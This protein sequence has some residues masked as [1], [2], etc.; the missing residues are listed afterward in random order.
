MIREFLDYTI[1]P[2]ASGIVALAHDLI[3]NNW[4]VRRLDRPRL[5]ERIVTTIPNYGDARPAKPSWFKALTRHYVVNGKVNAIPADPRGRRL[6]SWRFP[7][8]N[9]APKSDARPALSLLS[10][11]MSTGSNP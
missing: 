10:K 1:R 7:K 2:F 3:G 5:V 11:M 4:M 8:Q 6:A 9:A